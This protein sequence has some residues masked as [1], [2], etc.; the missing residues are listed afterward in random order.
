MY[1]FY[2]AHTVLTMIVLPST[3]AYADFCLTIY[4]QYDSQITSGVLV[5]TRTYET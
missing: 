4:T 3:T 2:A 5:Y 1:I